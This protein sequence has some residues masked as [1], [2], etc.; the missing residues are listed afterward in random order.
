MR[1]RFRPLWYLLPLA[2]GAALALAWVR[3]T[4]GST[5]AFTLRQASPAI[6]ATMLGATAAWLVLRF[7]RWQFLLRRIGVRLPIRP[8]LASYIAAL[9]GTATPA[10]IGE[11]ARAI[12]LRRRFGT[13]LRP[14]IL[15]LVLER[16][17]DV[18]ALALLAQATG[19]GIG[20]P[21]LVVAMAGAALL[22]AVARRA[23]V[24][25]SAIQRLRSPLAVAAALSASM[26]AWTIAGILYALAAAALGSQLAA[27]DGIGVFARSTLLGAVTLS[28]AGVGA[29]GSIAIVQL[30]SLGL[31]VG[32]AVSIVTLVRLASTGA[33]LAVGSAF[34]WRELRGKTRPVE[35]GVAHFDTIASEY[36]A[37]WS[38]HVWDLLLDRKLSLM[39]SALPSP[40]Q[41]A[42]IGVDLGCGLGIQTAE[43]R[44]RGFQVV[45]LEPSVGL[46][47]QNRAGGA[48]VVAA[49]ALNIPLRT[50]SVDF[51][52]VIG[53][54]HHL[55]GQ[56]AQD[57][58]LREIAR[59][60]RPD[61]I[62]LV[63]ES[64]PRNPLFRF[65]MGYLFPILKSIDE[66]TEWW[67]DPGRWRNVDG[68]TLATVRYFTFLPDFTPRFLMQPAIAIERWL[69]R[70][71]TRGFSAHY[72]AV[73]RRG[74]DAV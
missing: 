14:V 61:G 59:V 32:Q 24:A 39:A 37:Q 28:P 58:A 74:R 22:V 1:A 46:L 23:G 36:N 54:L 26:I 19:V 65:Y 8:T 29:T 20:L 44:R 55:P 62:L 53:V 69:E 33:A 42:G 18:A 51:V 50:A 25:H 4:G 5:L 34:L 7:L 11:V 13:P 71:P 60:L 12:F 73:L 56:P 68:L 63:H 2:L 49:D 30:Q 67:I 21:F 72:L 40:P 16:L 48:P 15:V 45:G 31:A 64:N 57:S 41:A 47:M 27:S 66:G 43:M 3:V 9:P 52:F 17:Y 38:P 35:E 10:Y 6:V 70:G